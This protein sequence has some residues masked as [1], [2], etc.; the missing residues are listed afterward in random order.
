MK[1]S[2]LPNRGVAQ[3]VEQTLKN[4]LSPDKGNIQQD[5]LEFA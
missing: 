1:I 3:L 5:F 2:F 4:K